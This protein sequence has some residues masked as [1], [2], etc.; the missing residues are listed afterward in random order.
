LS[1]SS[2]EFNSHVLQRAVNLPEET[3]KSD[4]II[5]NTGYGVFKSEYYKDLRKSTVIILPQ[6]IKSRKYN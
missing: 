2:C 4:R 5:R 6:E 3:S 1:G